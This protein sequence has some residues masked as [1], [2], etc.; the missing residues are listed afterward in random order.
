[1]PEQLEEQSA[2]Q[3]LEYLLAGRIF[4]RGRVGP[5]PGRG[6][7]ERGRGEGAGRNAAML[8]QFGGGGRKF[9]L[10]GL[11]VAATEEP[12]GAGHIMIVVIM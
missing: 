7:V 8:W 3:G 6:G 2:K 1:M 9:R 5:G 11:S 12:G 4:R 10:R